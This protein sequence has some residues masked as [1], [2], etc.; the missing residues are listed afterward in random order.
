M[1]KTLTEISIERFARKFKYRLS[2]DKH[3]F[4]FFLGAGCSISS[5]IPGS[6][7]LV[8][9][10]I[11]TLYE[12][13]TGNDIGSNEGHFKN[14][15]TVKYPEYTEENA[16]S[17]YGIVIK[18]LFPHKAER[19]AEFEKLIK[20]K[21][22]AFGYGVLA[23][24]VG[25]SDYSE[26]CNIIFTTNFDDL[27]ADALYIY[28]RRKPLVIAHESL[29]GFIR[30]TSK[31][32]IVIKLHGDVFLE[33][34]NTVD[35]IKEIPES[36]K[37]KLDDIL[38]ETGIVFI[39]YGGNDEGILK[40]LDGLSKDHLKNGIYWINNNLPD[41]P[42]FC[43]WLIER[44]AI[45]VRIE[46][47]DKLMLHLFKEFKLK[48]P[49][50]NR[51]D[52]LLRN[53]FET[54]KRLDAGLSSEKEKQIVKEV[55]KDSW[56]KF[57]L[58]AEK[59]EKTD[60]KKAD[61]IFQEG[62]TVFPNSGM[63]ACYYA[64][65]LKDNRKDYEK[66][67]TYYKKALELDP[68][69]AEITSNYAIFLKNIR[70][71]YDKAE[72]YYKKS[73]VLDSTAASINANYA[74]FLKDIRKDYER[75]ETYCKKALEIDPTNAEI[76]GLHAI[77]LMEIRKDYEKAETYYKKALDL[78][79]TSADIAGNY[80]I[81]LKNIR[82]DYDK[83]ETYYKKAIELDPTNAIK[84]GIYA[85]FLRDIR[86]DSE[87]AEIYYKK[88]IELDP[89]NAINIGSYAIFLKDIRKDFENGEHYYKK[90][91]ELDPSD[92]NHLGN[93]AGYLLAQGDKKEG[94]PILDRVFDLILKERRY[95]SLLLE[96]LFY[97][98]AH[99]FENNQQ[100]EADRIQIESMLKNGVRSIHWDFSQN[101]ERA[102]LDG[103]PHPEMLY[104]LA[105]QIS[106]DC[107]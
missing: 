99:F 100:M 52:D 5:K 82:K 101:I 36:L 15:L 90:A 89:T 60:Y 93:Y 44:G 11:K 50:R 10:W 64:I 91:L 84:H 2:H 94:K 26:Y 37:N 22:P 79:P 72:T 104:S 16:S 3:K 20:N 66:A 47:F 59:F 28:S 81:F 49:D 9:K 96:C 106:E 71:D 53:Y 55:T 48:S 43:E 23:Q 34:E 18:D 56:W 40:I 58:E 17:Y 75:A 105:Q 27:V 63:L 19:R 54:L 103:H 31:T 74:I 42:K 68:T 7:E 67:E 80:A 46:S 6:K 88:A 45:W 76:N 1:A 24:L 70:K 73:L 32:P 98:F 4:A 14:W 65:F 69:S 95:E 8:L 29:T 83:A 12:E 41:N 61:E 62:L 13:E 87:K 107:D 57:A 30:I 97:R 77:F 85:K 25:N 38:K 51:F 102:V 78:D 33:I 21:D 92:P 35:E 86:K 39:G